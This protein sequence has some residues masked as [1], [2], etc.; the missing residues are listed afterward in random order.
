MAKQARSARTREAL[1]R[2]AASVFD[3]AGYEGTALA[4]ISEAADISMGAL[5]FHFSSKKA[6]AE[7]VQE[8]GVATTRRVVEQV[9]AT[10]GASPLETVVSVTLALATLLG[11]DPLV[12]AAARLARERTDSA[13]DWSDCWLPTVEQLTALAA[14]SEC[15]G[16]DDRATVVALAQLLV[17][18]AEAHIRGAAR[19]E[20]GP[21]LS[22]EFA[23]IW[24]AML[25]G[26]TARPLVRPEPGRDEVSDGAPS[27]CEARELT[28]AGRVPAEAR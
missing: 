20:N 6:L 15:P 3:D 17:A 1:V 4:R 27:P 2:A 7:E 28:V 14:E 26:I 11:R 10:R 12:R 13:C 21:D 22:G 18:G 8:Q 19:A 25:R 9:A 16:R 5:T 24:E 23:R